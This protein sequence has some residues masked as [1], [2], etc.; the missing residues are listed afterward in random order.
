MKMRSESG[1]GTVRWMLCPFTKY[2]VTH[3]TLRRVM[4]LVNPLIVSVAVI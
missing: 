2:P 1:A 4:L 3:I